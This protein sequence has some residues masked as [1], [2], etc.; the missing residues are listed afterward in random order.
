MKETFSRWILYLAL[1]VLYLLHNDLWFWNTPQLALGLPIGLLYHIGFCVVAAILMIL[2][3]N[4]AWPHH[5]EAEDNKVKN[6]D[7]KRKCA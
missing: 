5:L 7:A 3:V 1:F 6:D 2:L 4:Y